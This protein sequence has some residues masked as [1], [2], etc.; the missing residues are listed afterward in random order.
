VD[1]FSGANCIGVD[2]IRMLRVFKVAFLTYTDQFPFVTRESSGKE[3][4]DQDS[5]AYHK[6]NR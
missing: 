4:D 2:G 5:D 1:G 3:T 6:N